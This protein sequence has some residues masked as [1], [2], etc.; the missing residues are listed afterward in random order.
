MTSVLSAVHGD[1]V[2]P[3]V[4]QSS[5]CLGSKPTGPPTTQG[6]NSLNQLTMHV[7]FGIRPVVKFQVEP[8]VLDT[9]E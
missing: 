8:L 4:T 1:G 9:F 5:D 3:G 6:Y 7:V 2:A